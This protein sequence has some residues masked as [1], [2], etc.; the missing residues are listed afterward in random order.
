[1]TAGGLSPNYRNW[2]SL[3]GAGLAT[4]SAVLFLVF[5]VSDLF[6]FH[7]NP[8]LGI[9][10]FLL[11]PAVFV[12][13]L[14]LV[15]LGLWRVR[16]RIARGQ[17]QRQWPTIDVGRPG[18][19]RTIVVLFVGHVSQ[20]PGTHGFARMFSLS[21]RSAYDQDG[22]SDYSRLRELSSHAMTSEHL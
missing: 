8:Y 2:T 20:Q 7:T 13:G 14:L 18:V 9:V 22:R 15:P 19:R 4:V 12:L 17:P 10:T 5:F 16:R 21:R 1:M 6:G 3:V 11:L